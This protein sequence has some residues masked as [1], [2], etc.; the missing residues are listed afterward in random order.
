MKLVPTDPPAKEVSGSSIQFV[1]CRKKI[2]TILVIQNFLEYDFL[3]FF[4][5][6]LTLSHS[7][8]ALLTHSKNLTTLPCHTKRALFLFLFSTFETKESAF[9]MS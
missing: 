3:L 7:S 5:P 2:Q 6:N 1:N 9:V 4:P 8:L